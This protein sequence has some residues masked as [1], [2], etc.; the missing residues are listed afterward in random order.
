MYNCTDL[1]AIAH[2]FGD[3]LSSSLRRAFLLLAILIQYISELRTNRN[4]V[5]AH[6]GFI[7]RT[8]ESLQVLTGISD[9]CIYNDLDFLCE[10]GLIE[11]QRGMGMKLRLDPEK[12]LLLINEWKMEYQ[13]WVNGEFSELNEN[14]KKFNER[15][16]VKIQDKQTLLDNIDY[17]NLRS[18]LD[19][20]TEEEVYLI[21][22]FSHYYRAYTGQDY[23]WTVIKLNTLMSV[24]KDGIYKDWPE[25]ALSKA[26]K[27]SIS[28]RRTNTYFEL[29]WRNH[30]T[31][32]I[33]PNDKEII[34]DSI[35]EED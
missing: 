9:K 31:P 25:R 4:Q 29:K 19:D 11:K 32:D 13:D 8:S 14:R 18:L 28:D 20:F 6:D 34:F 10:E 12:L 5:I 16:K 21:K 30:F 24:W 1:R 2:H 27:D 33:R 17:S 15:A 35:Y 22:L 23:K 26:I 3:N 7:V